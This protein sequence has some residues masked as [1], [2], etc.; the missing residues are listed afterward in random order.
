MNSPC[1]I[2]IPTMRH[3]CAMVL[4]SLCQNSSFANEGYMFHTRL[5]QGW[6]YSP[7]LLPKPTTYFGKAHHKCLKPNLPAAY[8]C[9]VQ[10]KPAGKFVL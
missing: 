9:I 8:F 4:R 6:G 7:Q 3:P 2:L 10:L 1:V 5:T